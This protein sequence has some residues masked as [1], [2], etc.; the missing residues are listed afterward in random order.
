M[1]ENCKISKRGFLK[2]ACALGALSVLPIGSSA[3]INNFTSTKNV[4]TKDE[5]WKWS[6]EADYY[7]NTPK[8]I[9]CLKCPSE[10]EI[11]NGEAGDC[12]TKVNYDGVLYTIA[13]GNPCAVN[14]DPIEKKPLY[15][16]FP[17]SRAFSIATAGCNLACL[18]CQNWTIS[19]I[20]PKESRNYDLM[21]DKTVELAMTENCQ[22]IAYTYS[23]PVAFYEYTLDTAKIAKLKGVKNVLVTAGYIY[24]KPLREWCQY[25]DAANVDLKS[26]SEE[27]YAQLNAGKLQPVLDALKI[28]KDEGIW[29][30]ITNLIVPGWTDDF[31]MIKK[32]CEW[33]VKN[34][35]ENAPMHFSRFHPMYQLTHLPATP[36]NT[37]RKAKQIAKSTGLNF[38]YI[39]NVPGEDQNTYCPACK[40]IVIERKGYR[41]L[42]NH[43]NA[44]NCDHCNAEVPGRWSL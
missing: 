25:V 16:F 31:D 32:M 12:K 42:Q 3:F 13:Y 5:P 8:G 28:M 22:S 34:G 23:D 11:K 7:I 27:T 35:F 43:M 4:K 21:P 6:R 18:N 20:S 24:E 40:K 10:C 44:G 14:V 29:I 17:A 9:R 26:F 37:L 30:E 33:L 1:E 2:G 39:G 38:V 41:I 36:I 15:H 19:Q